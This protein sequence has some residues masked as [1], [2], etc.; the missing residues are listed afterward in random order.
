MSDLQAS[1]VLQ[2]RRQQKSLENTC[3]VLNIKKGYTEEQVFSAD[4]TGLFYKNAGKWTCEMQWP[5]KLLALNH[6]KSG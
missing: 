6:S 4:E 2:T 1:Q 3:Q 5:P